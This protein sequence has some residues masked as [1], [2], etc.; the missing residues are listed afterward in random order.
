[1]EYRSWIR[2][3]IENRGSLGADGLFLRVTGCAGADEQ[4][5]E[6]QGT[7]ELCAGLGDLTLSLERSA[8]A[9]GHL[10]SV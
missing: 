1:M 8:E 5:V 3:I 10:E 6:C 9:E 7:V 4:R 2:Q